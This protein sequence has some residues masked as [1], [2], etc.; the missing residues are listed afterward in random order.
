[1]KWLLELCGW[2][3]GLALAEG[4]HARRGM[5]MFGRAHSDLNTVIGEDESGVGRGEFGGRHC[6]SVVWVTT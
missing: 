3:R 4:S 6:E 5:I 2:L 1:M